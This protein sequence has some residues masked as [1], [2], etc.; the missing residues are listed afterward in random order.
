MADRLPPLTAIRYFEAAA[1]HLSFTKAAEEL[2]VTHS[3]ISHQIKALEEWLGMPLF[4]RM[5]RAIVLT[6]AGQAYMRPVKEALR[7]AG[8]GVAHPEGAGADGH[9][10][11]VDHAVLCREVAGAADRQLP[12]RVSGYRRAHLRQRAAGGLQP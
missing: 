8:R 12:G 2:H 4:R 3:A 7:A 10:D 5:N 6:E 11:G 9:A 1:R